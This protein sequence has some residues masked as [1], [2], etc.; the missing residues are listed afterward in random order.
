[1]EE[2]DFISVVEEAWMKDVK[3]F[4]P[5]CVFRDR[6]KNVKAS[7]RIWSKERF[8]GHKE[9][10]DSLRNEAMRWKLEAEKRVL[11]DSE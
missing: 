9:K 11:N 4:Q 1:M 6:L 2:S 3:S 5:D 7:L 10:M 8:G